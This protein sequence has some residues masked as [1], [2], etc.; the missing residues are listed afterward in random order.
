LRGFSLPLE[1][2]V[3]LEGKVGI[4]TGAGSGMGAATALRWA[5]EGARVVVQDLRLEAA[6]GTASEITGSG[7]QAIAVQGDVS[8]EK[9]WERIVSATLAAF[10]PPTILH[11]NAGMHHWFDPLTAPVEDWDR[12]LDVNLRGV[13]LGCR[14]AI[15]HMIEAGGGAIVNTSSTAG[16]MGVPR[17]L[18]YAASKAGVISLTRSLARLYGRHNVRVNTVCPGAVDTPMLREAAREALE[19]NPRLAQMLESG[20][21]SALRRMAQPQEIANVVTFLV[22]DQASYVTGATIPVDGGSTA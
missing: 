16:L 3:L 15:P 10:G 5:Q 22:S 20:T 7:G 19:I 4:V 6:D 12:M 1:D 18:D 2:S 17:Q 13:F 21:G 14:A 9:D 8:D 11:N